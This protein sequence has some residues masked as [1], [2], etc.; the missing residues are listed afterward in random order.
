[1]TVK[2]YLLLHDGDDIQSV[3]IYSDHPIKDSYGRDTDIIDVDVKA[4]DIAKHEDREVSHVHL[5]VYDEPS[6]DLNGNRIMLQHIRA[7]I[8]VK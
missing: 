1:M 7:C 4:V 6:T 5:W 8:Y 3:G 2:E